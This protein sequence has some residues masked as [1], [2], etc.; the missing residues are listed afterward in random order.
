MIRNILILCLGFILCTASV[1]W[2]EGIFS[3]GDQ[4]KAKQFLCSYKTPERS[5]LFCEFLLRNYGGVLGQATV[6]SG[7]RGIVRVEWILPVESQV[8]PTPSYTWD[9]DLSTQQLLPSSNQAQV[10]T[11]AF[12]QPIKALP[13]LQ[14]D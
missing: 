2:L 12:H 5:E 3:E 11:E 10:W 9:I 1:F 4:T 6:M 8:R 13:P 14:L 7:C